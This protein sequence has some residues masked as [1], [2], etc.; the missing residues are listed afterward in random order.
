MRFAP[1]LFALALGVLSSLAAAQAYPNK[2]IRLIVAFPPGGT[3]DAIA[4]PLAERLSVALGQSVVVESRPGA[5]TMIA[6]ELVAKSQP[7]GYTLYVMSA[8]H[9]LTPYLIRKVPFDPVNDFTAITIFGTQAYVFAA[10]STQPFSSLK[11]MVAFAKTNAGG[12]S[13]GVSDATTQAVVE[14]LRA[15]TG[16]GF[17]VINYKGG[18]PIFTDLLGGQLP[19]GIVSPPVFAPYAKDLRLRGLAVSQPARMPLL[20]DV[21]SV[22]EALGGSGFDVQTWYGFAGPAN[23]PRPIVARLHAEIMKILAEPDM[24]KVIANVGLVAPADPSPEASQALLKSYQQ[25]MGTLLQSAG[26]KP[27]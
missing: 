5:Q 21:P 10:S 4:R 11:E 13:I 6:G 1:A 12:V 14:A 24:K 16:V 27:E 26:I 9:L 3:V 20:P 8:S 25:K 23:L 22:D 2:P 15:Q 7:D 18:G 19:V 17:T